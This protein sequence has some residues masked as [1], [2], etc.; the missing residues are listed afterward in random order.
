MSG[1]AEH[2]LA[3]AVA[4]ALAALL[5]VALGY[6][7]RRRRR[8][9]RRGRARIYR[10]AACGHVYADPRRVP[11]AGCTRCGALNEAVRR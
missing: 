4:A 9:P 3:G 8:Q 6:E 2:L 11:L 7:A 5:A 10:C 1:G